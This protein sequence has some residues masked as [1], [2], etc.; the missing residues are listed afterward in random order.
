MKRRGLSRLNIAVGLVAALAVAA[1]LLSGCVPGELPAA[2]PREEAPPVKNEELAAFIDAVYKEPY[3]YFFN[4]CVD[5]SLRIMAEAKRLGM[6]AD[7][8]G[9]IAIVPAKRWHNFPI[10]SPHVYTEIEGEKVDVALDPAR[11]KIYCKNSEVRII[12]AVNLSEIGR[13]FLERA[14]LGGYLLGEGW[15]GS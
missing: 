4:N 7:L 6:K 10:V 1:P 13:A 9:G 5:K 11:E 8:I 2:A 15:G 12:M 14:G 3:S